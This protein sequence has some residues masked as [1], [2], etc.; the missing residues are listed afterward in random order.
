MVG[1]VDN[2]R[3]IYRSDD[4]G[5]TWVHINDDAH[6]WGLVLQISGDPKKYGRVYV[7]THG[8]GVFYGDPLN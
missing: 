7:G 5:K 2:A 6:Q 3:G 4:A 1:N 8:R